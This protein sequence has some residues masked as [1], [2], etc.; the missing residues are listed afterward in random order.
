V[1]DADA[2]EIGAGVDQELAGETRVAQ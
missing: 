1:G 2:L